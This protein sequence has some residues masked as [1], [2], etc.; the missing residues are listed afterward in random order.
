MATVT[1]SVVPFTIPTHVTIDVPIGG[2]NEG[3]ASPTAQVEVADLD[4]A[5]RQALIDDFSATILA[6]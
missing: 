2:K 4:V 3:Y 1:L 5:T 6:L